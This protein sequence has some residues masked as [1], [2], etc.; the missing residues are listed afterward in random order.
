MAL[1]LEQD[2]WMADFFAEV[3]RSR[4]NTWTSGFVT[5]MEERYLLYG[6]SMSVSPKQWNKL[7]QIRGE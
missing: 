3:D 5:D 4:M 2:E 6:S 1:T 7:K